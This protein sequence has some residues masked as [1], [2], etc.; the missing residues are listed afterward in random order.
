MGYHIREEFI[1]GWGWYLRLDYMDYL[2]YFSEIE[3]REDEEKEYY[4]ELYEEDYGDL[5][6]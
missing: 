6:D 5:E 2:N 4:E 1:L 3:I